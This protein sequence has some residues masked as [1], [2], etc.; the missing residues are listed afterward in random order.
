MHAGPVDDR[1]IAG[2]D[3][4]LTYVSAPLEEPLDVVGPV[5]FVLH[6]SSSAPDTDWHVR[7][8]D[9]HDDGALLQVGAHFPGLRVLERD[10]L[11]GVLEAIHR[12]QPLA[13]SR[14]NRLHL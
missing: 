4:V 14:R 2:R 9:V 11:P 3:D 13:A 7:L 1:E 10:R 5:S 6:A 8:V 12:G